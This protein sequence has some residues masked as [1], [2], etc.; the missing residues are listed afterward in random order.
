MKK[1]DNK[2]SALNAK[3]NPLTKIDK[4][5]KEKIKINNEIDNN[6]SFD[7]NSNS[8]RKKL[9]GTNNNLSKSFANLSGN[10]LEEFGEND[11]DNKD[12]QIKNEEKNKEINK[13]MTITTIKSSKSQI[14]KIKNNIYYESQKK[15]IKEKKDN[16]DNKD[17]K[18]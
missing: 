7:S 14:E 1:R 17:I 9:L 12:N 18:I 13:Y 4:K 10:N 11:N 8:F 6:I 16:K 3:K 2:D 15:N 5:V